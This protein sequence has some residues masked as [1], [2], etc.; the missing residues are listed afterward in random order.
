MK[1]CEMLGILFSHSCLYYFSA[2]ILFLMK[3]I[4]GNCFVTNTIYFP[5]PPAAYNS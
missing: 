2:N 4:M 5:T 1:K 3:N